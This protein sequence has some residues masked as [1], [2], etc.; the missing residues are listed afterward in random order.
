MKISPKRTQKEDVKLAAHGWRVD[1]VR[2]MPYKCEGVKVGRTGEH[3][4][5][6]LMLRGAGACACGVLGIHLAF[7]VYV[8]VLVCIRHM[9]TCYYCTLVRMQSGVLVL[10]LNPLH[11]CLMRE[12]V[13][14]VQ[15][16][17]P[18]H[19]FACTCAKG[20]SHV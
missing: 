11:A 8:H 15:V 17:L 13:P 16:I 1:T 6:T 19:V 2:V 3:V 5:R 20:V 9:R 12:T 4:S 7:R 10:L 14:H 18:T